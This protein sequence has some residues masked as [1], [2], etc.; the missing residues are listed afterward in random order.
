MKVSVIPPGAAL[1]SNALFEGRRLDSGP[2]SPN[3]HWMDGFAAVRRKAA[4]HGMVMATDDV[5]AVDEADIVVHMIYPSRPTLVAEQKQRRPA[6]KTVLVL[7]ETAVGAA[8]TFNP[9][10][11]RDF[12][13]VITYDDRLVDGRKYFPMRPRAYNRSRIRTGQSFSE[14]R[15]G[16]LVGTDRPFRYRSGLGL[17]ARGWHVSWRDWID[18]VFC[19][20]ELIRYRTGLGKAFAAFPRG[21]FDIYGEG[22][23]RN[24]ETAALALGIPARS[25]LE[26]LGDYRY[27]MAIENHSGDHSLI[28]ERIWDALWGDS[29][30]VYYGNTRIDRHI[31]R[32]CYVDASKFRTPGDLLQSLVD[33]PEATWSAQR[34]AGRQFIQGRGVEPYLPEAFAEEFLTPILALAGRAAAPAGRMM[35]ANP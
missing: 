5:L 22:W 35:V 33:T 19:P 13:A 8:Y 1:A 27:A 15:I 17:M 26:Y 20:G 25:A 14:R 4:A 21:S 30:P 2:H 32:E 29:V 10:N 11:H 9:R 18:Y 34:Q 24:P 23:E 12:D 31:P 16:C 7:L 6:L 3:V 28:S